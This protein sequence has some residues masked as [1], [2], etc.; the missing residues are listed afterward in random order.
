M[1]RWIK[2]PTKP[3]PTTEGDW[4]K[5]LKRK[6]SV[7]F[8][9]NFGMENWPA[10]ESYFGSMA[11]EITSVMVRQEIEKVR[12][13]TATEAREEALTEAIGV[14]G[15]DKRVEIFTA[16][17]ETCGMFGGEYHLPNCST[18]KSANKIKKE[19]RQ[20]LERLKTND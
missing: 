18:T 6:L 16:R 8:E 7:F 19:I 4:E 1:P 11:G 3:T 13:E 14:V 10:K 20:R 15:E 5:T 12:C 17:C 9:E 2:M